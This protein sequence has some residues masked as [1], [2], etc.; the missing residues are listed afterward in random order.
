MKTVSYSRKTYFLAMTIA[1]KVCLKVHLVLNR[2][3]VKEHFDD[4]IQWIERHTS[5]KLGCVHTNNDSKFTII[6]G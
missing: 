4:K 6:N 3:N 1:E 5:M 2:D